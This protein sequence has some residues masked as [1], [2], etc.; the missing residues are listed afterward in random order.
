MQIG[1]RP[2]WQRST[3][4]L[5]GPQQPLAPRNRNL[6]SPTTSYPPT[7]R[8]CAPPTL[9]PLVPRRCDSHSTSTSRNLPPGSMLAARPI[10]SLL[11][12]AVR[13]KAYRA[14]SS[15]SCADPFK[16]IGIKY[17]EQRMSMQ[18]PLAYTLSAVHFNFSKD[19]FGL[20]PASKQKEA[21]KMRSK[22]PCRILDFLGY[23]H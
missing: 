2:W 16:A 3:P 17:V 9:A 8:P 1:R 21:R 20:R 18:H 4:P 19:L 6:D 22:S 11:E 5:S 13:S 15:V 7:H 23:E 14:L 10:I 12:Y